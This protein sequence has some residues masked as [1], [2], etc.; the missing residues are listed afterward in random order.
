MFIQLAIILII[1][2]IVAF[3]MFL[4]CKTK[5]DEL[6]PDRAMDSIVGNDMQKKNSLNE[7][8]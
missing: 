2:F 1:I 4:I 3:V 7:S 5:A 8:I 6:F